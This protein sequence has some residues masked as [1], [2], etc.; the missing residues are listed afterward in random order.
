MIELSD[1]GLVYADMKVVITVPY[2]K[3]FIKFGLGLL[4]AV[5]SL[6]AVSAIDC[7]NTSYSQR[8]NCENSVG[9]YLLIRGNTYLILS[10]SIS[11]FVLDAD[12]ATL[13]YFPNLNGSFLSMT[14]QEISEHYPSPEL[15]PPRFT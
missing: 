2:I 6:T 1:R 15:K 11:S 10:L 12:K 14:Q 9:T 3:Q 4:F 5:A 13:P 8:A 7:Q